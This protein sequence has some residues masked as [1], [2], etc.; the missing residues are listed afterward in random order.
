MKSE[1]KEMTKAWGYICGTKWD[2]DRGSGSSGTS[3]RNE[4]QQQQDF[5][6]SVT[7]EEENTIKTNHY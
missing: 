1:V 4:H 2:K 6:Y 5:N 3:M 7:S